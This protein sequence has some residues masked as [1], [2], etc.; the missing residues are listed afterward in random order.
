MSKQLTLIFN[1]F[2]VEHLGKDVFLA[3][4][5][6]GH[7]LGYNVTIVYPLTETNKDFPKEIRGVKLV[8]IRLKKR[9]SWFPFWRTW[10][11]YI[12]L[13]RNSYSVDVLMRFHLSIHTLLMTIIY[14][15]I[16]PK[17]VVYVKMDINPNFL[18]KEK[19]FKVTGFKSW[20]KK[21]LYHIYTRK[22][23]ICSCET[24]LAYEYLKKMQ[25]HHPLYNLGNKLLLVPNGF[26]EELLASFH[27]NERAFREKEKMMITVGRLGTYPKNT[28]ML[29]DALEKVDLVD[30]NF[31][32]IGPIEKSFEA[33]IENFY[34]KNPN[35]RDN[36][37]FTGPIFNKK[38]LW[39]YYNR[40]KVF[41]LTSRYE[42][43]PIVFPE[44][45]RFQNYIISTDVGAFSDITENGKYGV[46]INQEDVPDLVDKM[47]RVI[48]NKINIDVYGA[49]FDTVSLSWK[50]KMHAV[51]NVLLHV[52][53][54][55]NVVNK[56]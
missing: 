26:D 1:H 54:E 55:K 12:Y 25:N 43:S 15:T 13:L 21:L 42:G 6:L 50:Y 40:A 19:F 22:L 28:E 2:E 44:A 36:V 49:N 18:L 7:N 11:F 48:S 51:A 8:P 5:Y 45:R 20:V 32:L 46:S 3:P 31:Y 35:K 47:N 33:R 16:H 4:F 56:S 53:N 24:S 39:E 30:W 27:M 29:L 14:K 10:N 23:D 37:I 17:G 34:R 9:L 41:V 38:Q 52:G